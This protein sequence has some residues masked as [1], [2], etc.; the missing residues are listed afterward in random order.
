V[1]Q[2]AA[3]AIIHNTQANTQTHYFNHD[4]DI[5][6]I[7]KHPNNKYFATG[8]IGPKPRLAIW[9]STDPSQTV[10]QTNSWVDKGV[11]A[12][13]FSPDGSK[14]AACCMD[15]KNKV[16]LFDVS[17]EEFKSLWNKE[18]GN[19]KYT[20]VIWFSEAEFVAF[21]PDVFK[22]WSVDKGSS[23]NSLPSKSKDKV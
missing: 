2:A 18:G 19:K 6:S 22:V 21:G 4:D 14:L 10:M 11:S 16:N 15:E 23:R 7:T 17:G 3:V 5:I 8:E 9:D 1:W 20:E 12:L 13:G